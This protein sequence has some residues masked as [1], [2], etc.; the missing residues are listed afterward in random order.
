MRG[1]RPTNPDLAQPGG[2]QPQRRSAVAGRERTRRLPDHWPARLATRLAVA[3][4]QPMRATRIEQQ[5]AAPSCS[6]RLVA[7]P[8]EVARHRP[9]SQWSMRAGERI[10]RFSRFLLVESPEARAEYKSDANVQRS[11]S[12]PCSALVSR[13]PDAARLQ[14]DVLA[15]SKGFKLGQTLF[16]SKGWAWTVG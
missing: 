2:S 10:S 5:R 8:R 13:M 6:Y 1:S 7:R 14:F 9:R 16:N 12:W 3:P 15:P 11:E 4:C